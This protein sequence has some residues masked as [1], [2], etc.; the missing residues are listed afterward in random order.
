[1]LL[2]QTTR[3]SVTV[4]SLPTSQSAGREGRGWQWNSEKLYLKV[5]DSTKTFLARL[6]IGPARGGQ[7]VDSISLGGLC[8]KKKHERGWGGICDTE[9]QTLGC[10]LLWGVRG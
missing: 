2:K 7:F 4:I 10:C 9:Y 5:K 1:M 3:T 8:K 6:D